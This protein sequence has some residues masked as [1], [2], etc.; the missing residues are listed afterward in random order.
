MEA[1]HRVVRVCL[2][3][4]L[5]K[6]HQSFRDWLP[7]QHE[8]TLSRNREADFMG[9]NILKTS[10]IQLTLITKVGYNP[11]LEK[12]VAAVLTVRLC[13]VKK[14]NIR[15]VSLDIIMEELCI[16]LAHSPRDNMSQPFYLTRCKH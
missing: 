14:L 5:Y 3:C 9:M 2:Q 4:V 8:L 10:H 13:N 15:G 12:P 16:I 11:N 6:I 7:I 1:N